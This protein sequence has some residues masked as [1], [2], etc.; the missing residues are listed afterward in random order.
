M[1]LAEFDKLKSLELVDELRQSSDDLT[2]LARMYVVTGDSSYF[3]YFNKVISIRDGI[4]PR[5]V[6]YNRV[7]WDVFIAEG[8]PPRPDG[9]SISLINLVKK[10]CKEEDIVKYFNDAKLSSDDLIKVEQEA[11]NALKGVYKDSKG[12]FT[13]RGEPN[14]KLA[15]ELLH[16]SKYLIAKAKIMRSIDD[17]YY[18]VNIATSKNIDELKQ[19]QEFFTDILDGVFVIFLIVLSA[20][21]IFIF[22]KLLKITPESQNQS[23]KKKLIKILVEVKSSWEII[24]LGIVFSIMV[25]VFFN[26]SKN[27]VKNNIRND[28]EDS[29]SI[30]LETTTDNITNWIS[31][32]EK[33]LKSISNSE[34]ITSVFENLEGSSENI[35]SDTIKREMI[36]IFSSASFKEYIITDQYGNIKFSS[37]SKWSNL[38]VSNLDS[39]II[40]ESLI[41]SGVIFNRFPSEQRSDEQYNHYIKF[42]IPF[43]KNGLIIAL[44]DP[45]ERFT[46]VLQAGRLGKSGESYALNSKGVMISE[47]RFTN[48]LQ[49][50]GLI[51]PG[52]LSELN[53]EIRDPKSNYIIRENGNESQNELTLMAQNV[54]SGFSGINVV[55]YNDYRGILVIGA[56]NWLDEYKIG[57]TTEIDYNEAYQTVFLFETISLYA[58]IFFVLLILVL[59]TVFIINRYKMSRLNSEIQYQSSLMNSLINAIPDLIFF[60]DTQM[61]FLGANKAFERQV[62]MS[63]EKFIGKSDRSFLPEPVADKFRK[64]DEIIIEE[65]KTIFLESEDLDAKGNKIIYDTRKSPFYDNEGKL[66]GI[67]GVSRDITERKH[68][69]DLIIASENK[70]RSITLTASDAIISINSKGIIESWNKASETI[71]GYSAN[72]ALGRPIDIIIPSKYHSSHNEGLARVVSG[73]KRHAIGKTVELVGLRKDGSTFPVDLS[74]STW[75][76]KGEM[77]FSGIIRDVTER[78]LYQ[79]AI[80]ESNKRMSSELNVAKDI[81]MSMLPLIFPAFPK[82]SEIDIYANLIPA[83][84][85]GGDF[86]DFHFLDDNHIYFV[87][88]DVSGKGVP[89]A[90][91]MAV[92]KTLLKSTAGND[93]S[94][95]SILT[96][97]N[98]EIA[99]DNEAYMFIT[100]FIAILN[101]S[102]GELVYSNAGHNPSF[103]IK[104]KREIIKLE[105]LHGPV[106]GAMEDMTYT[107]TKVTIN[108]NDIVFAYTDGITEAHNLKEELYSDP[109][110]IGL[111][112]NGEYNDPKTLIKLV[113]D[114]VL[115]F[116]GEAEQFDDITALSLQYLDDKELVMHNSFSVAI[117]NQ[118]DQMPQVIESF[119]AFGEKNE[120]SFGVIQ[121]FNIALDELLNNIISY[122][123][124]DDLDHD[125]NVDVELRNE[126]LIITLTDDGVPFNPFR[127]DPPDTKLSIDERNIGGLGIHIVKNLVDEYDYKRQSDKNIITLVKYNINK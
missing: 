42:G 106:V 68:Q 125:I 32:T 121:K 83:R 9:E 95:A 13:V 113:E 51:E 57:I 122:G 80:E 3:N 27:T 109:R 23:S 82:R 58:E 69:E 8:A 65:Q 53:I 33:D 17:F 5:P 110:L 126:R 112:E 16:G 26:I 61:R 34:L 73:G 35:K 50:M 104:P 64:S 4:I 78:K 7:Y 49:E 84:E 55:G 108:K 75:S 85:V 54:L 72:E 100:I 24:L 44:M 99:K 96:H 79:K 117:K 89:A 2:R 60:K 66:L 115:K 77:K 94:T 92:T 38:N 70:F 90:L 21:I 12:D 15:I 45:Q 28:I 1:N 40:P 97:V 88:G 37:N 111:L 14:Q 39:S 56:W 47:S 124:Q 18:Y 91:M 103:I 101:T 86:Y 87:V 118:L 20:S 19:Q 6:D 41:S 29:L 46:K 63:K 31:D 114:S 67:I 62:G 123:F 93:R 119:E 76:E 120:L 36:K 48:Q 98:N 116:Q 10:Y 25:I 74:L 71:F 59:I 30:I 105:E 81:Q 22:S 127:N 102:T 52:Q 43:N 11:F 107:E